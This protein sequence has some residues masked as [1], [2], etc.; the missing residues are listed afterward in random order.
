MIFVNVWCSQ[1]G[2]TFWDEI[3]VCPTCGT[4]EHLTER[5][6]GEDEARGE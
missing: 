6:M 3:A 2:Y 4:G 5:W 1:C